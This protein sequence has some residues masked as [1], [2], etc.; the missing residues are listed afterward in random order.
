V[1]CDEHPLVGVFLA[2]FEPGAVA[3]NWKFSARG[4]R[5]QWAG[6]APG[7]STLSAIGFQ[8]V[9]PRVIEVPD[10]SRADRLPV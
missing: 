9:G 5:P 10:F 8:G 4:N 2:V 1:N 7:V 6:P 3:G